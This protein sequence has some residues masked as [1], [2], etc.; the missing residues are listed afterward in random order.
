MRCAVWTLLL[1]LGCSNPAVLPAGA[2]DD[3]GVS[4]TGGGGPPRTD[5]FVV[6]PPASDA[7]PPDAVACSRSVH[8]TA[9]SIARPVPFDVVIV[10]DNS[11]SLSWSRSSLSAGLENLLAK[12]H[13]HEARFF[14]LT[15]TQYGASSKAAISIFDEKPLV[16]WRDSVTGAAYANPVTEYKQTC[17]DGKG[18]PMACPTTQMATQDAGPFKLEG[19]WQFQMPPPVAAITPQMTTAQLLVQQKKI[20]DA[21]LALGGGGA[22]QEQPICTLSRYLA[23]KPEALPKNVVFVVLT[24]ED[25]TSPPDA[26]LAGYRAGKEPSTIPGLEPCTSNCQKYSY[27]ADRPRTEDEIKFTC[28][29]V[30]DM[31]MAHPEKAVDK[32]IQTFRSCAMPS[33]VDCSSAE[34]S[35]AAAEC[36]AG[37]QVK[38]CKFT[39]GPVQGYLY[40]SLDVATD[41]VDL[42]SKPF[43]S[44]GAHY[45][46]LLDYCARTVGGTG[47]ANCH[48]GGWKETG[49]TVL[50]DSEQ[51]LPVVQAASTVEMIA[52]FKSSADRLFGA[53]NYSV[54][55][56]IF[57]PTFSCPLKPGQSFAPNLRA[58]ASGPGDVFP[59]CQDY[60]P[61][62]ARIQSFADYL[63]QNDF[64]LD[65]DAYEDVDSVVVTDRA[66]MQRTV[67]KPQ[68][69]YD[70]AAK[71]LRFTPGVLGAQDESLAV[72]VARYCEV[73]K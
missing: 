4:A 67:Q 37:N 24:D 5:A 72:N 58:L 33:T 32:V 49:M 39:C 31:G 53:R 14:V 15:T 10:A 35:K 62:V 45:Q 28:L 7:R 6:L 56:I 21:V 30:D 16:S 13:G 55:S 20:A 43:D 64:P 1:S 36:G 66:G 69:R 70:R 54:E 40:C 65:L 19:T 47:W 63:I 59:I 3:G 51:K 12:V 61:A 34:L 26:C 23:Q 8:L 57:D 46:N 27:Y 52:A 71:V 73:V 50:Q 11:D 42:C 22:Q 29:P 48:H 60:A 17:T 38:N 9:V 25:D 41:A 18:A 68:F 2:T 44:G